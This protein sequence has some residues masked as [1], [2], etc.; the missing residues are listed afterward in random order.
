MV[1]KVAALPILLYPVL[2]VGYYDTTDTSRTP[3]VS[4]T[5]R[6]ALD[7]FSNTSQ[8]S[9]HKDNKTNLYVL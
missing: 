9:L 1:V 5:H 6:Q 7:D 4:M 3:V 2:P 8:V